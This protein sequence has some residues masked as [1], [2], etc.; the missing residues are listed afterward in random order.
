[1][2]EIIFYVRVGKALCKDVFHASCAL[3]AWAVTRGKQGL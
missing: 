3:G 2:S 1:M